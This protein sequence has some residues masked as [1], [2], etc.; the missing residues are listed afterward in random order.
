M[1]QNG[2]VSQIMTQN[3]AVGQVMSQPGGV[4]QIMT[5]NGTT[6]GQMMTVQVPVSTAGGIVMQNVQVP[7]QQNQNSQVRCPLLDLSAG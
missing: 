5:Q 3:G 1:T 2:A 6:V 7:V 4:G